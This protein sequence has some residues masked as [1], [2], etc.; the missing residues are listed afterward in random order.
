MSRIE[1]MP[2]ILAEFQYGRVD[3]P[4]RASSTVVSILESIEADS[5]GVPI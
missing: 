4:W 1:K 2:L 5:S 3:S